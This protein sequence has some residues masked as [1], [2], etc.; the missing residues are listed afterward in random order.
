MKLGCR[1]KLFFTKGKLTIT[2]R[3]ALMKLLQKGDKDPTDPNSFLPIRL[4]SVIYKLASCAIS[5]RINTTLKFIIW[6]QQKAYTSSGNIG[7]CLLNL[8][9]TMLHCN[10]SKKDGLLLLIDFRK[11]FDSI[12]HDY[13]Y[14]VME[15]LNFGKD[16]IEWMRLFL[17]ERVAH[18]LMGG[19]LTLKIPLEQGV[20]QGDIISPFIIIIAVEI[21]LIKIT[22]GKH[23]KGIKLQTEEEI[24]AQTF[25]DYTS[26]LIER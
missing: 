1:N 2:L 22:K 8:L 4:L 23:I 3:T 25:A 26:L 21:L 24:R 10:K 15:S 17:T 12:D 19:H 13:I 18:L 16:I 6:K 7:T 20:P 5:N 11:A 9:T 14:K